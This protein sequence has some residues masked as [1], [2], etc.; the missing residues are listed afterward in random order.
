MM[1][2]T[3]QYTSD[4]EV[5]HPTKVT[6]SIKSCIGSYSSNSPTRAL[7]TADD[8]RGTEADQEHD[9]DDGHG[10]AQ[11]STE[12]HANGPLERARP[13]PLSALPVR[14]SKVARWRRNF[15]VG[16]WSREVRCLV[17]RLPA[18]RAEAVLRPQLLS[19]VA[20]VPVR[21]NLLPR[22]NGRAYCT[23]ALSDAS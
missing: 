8:M 11:T 7:A 4:C 15:D 21:L 6:H 19:A 16:L 12:A 23:S 20:A 3:T 13:P 22:C 5:G 14:S 18:V 2:K 17:G 1:N 10:D 9:G